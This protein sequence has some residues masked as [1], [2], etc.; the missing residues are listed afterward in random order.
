MSRSVTIAAGKFQVNLP[1][2]RLYNAGQTVIL[3]DDQWNQVNPA[4]IP[5]TI[6]DNGAVGGG[7]GGTVVYPYIIDIDM[8]MPP[9]VQVGAWTSP[10]SPPHAESSGLNASRSLD[11]VLGTG[12]WNLDQMGYHGPDAGICTWALD[13]GAGVFTTIGTIDQ[14][15]AAYADRS[16]GSIIG[17]VVAS[18]IKR[19]LRVT[20]LTKNPSASG[21]YA[22]RFYTVRLRRTG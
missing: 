3:S 9:T 4:L 14:Y 5:G 22:M 13:D 6:I 8:L 7:G 21:S 1:D 10:G 2:G 18:S 19:V 11:V 20:A 16:L 12:T 15:S 17:F